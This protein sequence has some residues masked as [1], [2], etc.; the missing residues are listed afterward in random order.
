MTKEF[1]TNTPPIAE[2]YILKQDQ[3]IQTDLRASDILKI[4]I[5]IPSEFIKLETEEGNYIG[6]TSHK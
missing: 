4:K 6:P 2:E 3:E 5:P 1:N